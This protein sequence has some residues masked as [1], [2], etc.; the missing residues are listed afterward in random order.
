VVSVNYHLAPEHRFPAA[1]DGGSRCFLSGDSAGGNLTHHVKQHWTATAFGPIRIAGIILLQPYFSGEERTPAELRLD[2]VAPVV[3]M[4]RSDLSC[5]A[6]LPEGADRNHP[7]VHVTGEGGPEPE[8]AEAFPPAMV[9]MSGLDPL[10]DWQ[11]RYATMLE[12]KGRPCC[13]DLNLQH[14]VCSS[15]T[16]Q[17][18]WASL[19]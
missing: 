12:R 1:Y 17:F 16:I 18:H 2:G 9:V 11:R 8:L 3:N 14:L 4:P 13:A 15:V 6:F 10:R 5:R 19:L 7:A